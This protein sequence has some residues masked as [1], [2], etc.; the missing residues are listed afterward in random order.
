MAK[1]KKRNGRQVIEDFIND[2]SPGGTPPKE[3]DIE[4]ITD[5]QQLIGQ[6]LFY[7]GIEQAFYIATRTIKKT[8]DATEP[9]KSN[10]K[11]HET[12]VKGLE[13]AFMTFAFERRSKII[14]IEKQLHKISPML[15][16]E[17]KKVDWSEHE[18][19]SL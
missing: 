18:P 16:R 17:L 5:P 14:K 19:D 8:R 4:S 7:K 9:F 13:S 2:S 10:Y 3:I 6:Y 12:I 15:A 11:K 1:S